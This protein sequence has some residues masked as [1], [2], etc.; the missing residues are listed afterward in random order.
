MIKFPERTERILVWGLYCLLL[1][2]VPAL[3]VFSTIYR[4]FFLAEEENLFSVKAATA[5]VTVQS[6]LVVDQEVFWC[7][8]LHGSYLKLRDS[9]ASHEQ[10]EKWVRKTRE[11]LNNEYEYISWDNQGNIL[12]QTFGFDYSSE[13]W[14]KVFNTLAHY[15]PFWNLVE[16]SRKVKP[17][18][19]VTKKVLGD[20]YLQEFFQFTF[21]QRHYSLAYTDATM[22]RPVF[23]CMFFNNCAYLFAFKPEDFK[24]KTGLKQYLQNFSLTSGFGLGVY[25]PD[26]HEVWKTKADSWNQDSELKS[27]LQKC[28]S[29]NL[30][31]IQVGDRYLFFRFIDGATRI[32]LVANQKYSDWIIFKYSFAG[33]LLVLLL[34]FPV[35]RFLYKTH[36]CVLP[37]DISIRTKLAFL[38]AFASGIPLLVLGIISQ[39]NYGH[40]RTELINRGKRQLTEQVVNFDNRF[41]AHLSSLAMEMRHFFAKM[42]GSLKEGMGEQQAFDSIRERMLGVG[43]DVFFVVSSDTKTLYSYVGLIRLKGSLEDSKVDEENTVFTR[44]SVSAAIRTDLNTANLIG[45]KLLSDLNNSPFPLATV[46]KLELVAEAIMQKPFVEILHSVVSNFD[47]IGIWGFGRAQDYG[48]SN[49][50]SVNSENLFDYLAMV[51]WRPANIQTSYVRR[52]IEVAARNGDDMRLY[53]FRN[54]DDFMLPEGEKVSDEL[55][56][57]S[58]VLN[59]RPNE[60]LQ[61]VSVEGQ[62]YIVVGFQA[63]KLSDFRLIGLYPL[64]G[65]DLSI[66][67]QRSEIL[68]FSIFCLLFSLGLAQTLSRSFLHPVDELKNGALAIEKRNF[69]HR[70]QVASKDE[71]GKIADIFN[72]V[73]VGLEE[74]EVAKIVQESLFPAPEFDYPHFRV[75]GRSITM[76]ELGGDY[77]DFIRIDEKNF[78]V[79]MGDVAGH[80]VGAAVLMAMA[81]AAVLNADGLVQQP[82]ELL[83][84]LHQMILAAK[85]SK[86][87]KVMTFQYLCINDELATGVYSNAGA[88]SPMLITGKGSSASELTLAGPA[89]GAFKKATYQSVDLKFSV[90]DA[91]VLYTDGIVETR[92]ENGVEIGYDGFKQ[93]LL[94]SWNEDPKIFYD[95]VLA[96]YHRHLGSQQAQDDLT[97]MIM[98]CTEIRV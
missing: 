36:V 16:Y 17:D 73:M 93:I 55:I 84:R 30:T 63:Q 60:D 53:A 35:F 8:L 58:R 10:I 77:F 48:F 9:N 22:K 82:A 21:D 49:L 92:D 78:A 64:R 88:C 72:D 85:S 86:Q 50:L 1:A 43:A 25:E 81:K 20:Q 15:F 80:G 6:R 32:F 26:S 66:Q 54:G 11:N 5:K 41:S 76:S 12:K 61:I 34:L 79:L 89:L 65:V 96:G 7:R 83:L 40:K 31:F 27:R 29:E 69:E 13:D 47:N 57:F 39:E 33:S 45:K 28:E 23:F 74:L 42:S 95:N 24:N 37:G 98:V 91:V 52:F 87:R 90:G 97:F 14:H 71:F 67:Q 38:F 56:A 75:Y 59:D 68:L 94:D 70:V 44:S 2:G 62:N 19:E 51:F 46:S 4:Y 18:V 3:I